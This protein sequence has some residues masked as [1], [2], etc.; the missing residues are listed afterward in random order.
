MDG[1]GEFGHKVSG[2]LKNLFS[3]T[4]FAEPSFATDVPQALREVNVVY[5]YGFVNMYICLFIVY[6][7]IYFCECLF[8]CLY[9]QQYICFNMYNPPLSLSLS[10][11]N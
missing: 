8:C 5:I 3:K 2:F 4:L 1:H 9:V 6:R 7:F 11:Y 10:V